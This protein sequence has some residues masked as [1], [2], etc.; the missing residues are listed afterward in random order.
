MT[1]NASSLTRISVDTSETSANNIATGGVMSAD[2]RYVVF[3]STATNLV[4]GDANGLFD[5]FLR[6]TQTGT[7][8]LISTA[9]G[10]IQGNN[11]S[12][13][14]S[15]SDDGRFVFFNSSATNLVSGEN[16]CGLFGTS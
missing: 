10:G 5:V 3:Q 15:V 11:V 13:V 7:T 2:G 12:S 8:I 4:A 1:V 14:A 9:T 6:D 16:V